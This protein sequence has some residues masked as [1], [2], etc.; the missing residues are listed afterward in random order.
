MGR[1]VKTSKREKR[2]EKKSGDVGCWVWGPFISKP[3][4]S[5]GSW[6]LQGFF[7]FGTMDTRYRSLRSLARRGRWG[8]S[9]NFSFFLPD[10]SPNHKR[11]TPMTPSLS[12]LPK[13]YPDEQRARGCAP[14]GTRLL[15]VAK[16]KGRGWYPAFKNY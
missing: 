6:I 9:P 5:P 14:D 12:L 3:S 1:Q 4:F 13:D 7:N 16:E 8:L 11:Y 10:C 15:H 2:K